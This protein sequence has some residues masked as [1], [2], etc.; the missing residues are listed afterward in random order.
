MTYGSVQSL[1]AHACTQVLWIYYI[2]SN[3]SLFNF[4]LFVQQTD[5]LDSLSMQYGVGP[6]KYCRY[7]TLLR[8]IAYWQIVAGPAEQCW[9]L[10]GHMIFS[11]FACA[12]GKS[13]LRGSQ[14]YALPGSFEKLCC[15][16][17]HYL[18]PI[19]LLYFTHNN[20]EAFL[21][22]SIALKAGQGMAPLLCQ[23]SELHDAILI[24]FKSSA[25]CRSSVVVTKLEGSV[26]LLYK[27]YI[28]S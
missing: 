24:N 17:C 1:D 25:A 27:L 12:E 13:F 26:W 9:F 28:S 22:F 11:N 10:R 19:F 14:A 6:S 3:K 18:H 20:L 15:L 23:P 7:F 16:D 8:V 2:R 21:F 4:V 5:E